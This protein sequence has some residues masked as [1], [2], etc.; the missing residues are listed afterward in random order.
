MTTPSS[1]IGVAVSFSASTTGDVFVPG[2]TYLL[3]DGSRMV[4]LPQTV[5]I[6][7]GKTVELEVVR[8]A[9]RYERIEEDWLEDE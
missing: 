6:A 8:V 5:K 2:G 1:P 9:T 4:V 7:P 3:A